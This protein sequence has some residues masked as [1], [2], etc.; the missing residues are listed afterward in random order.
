MISD[1]TKG[2]ESNVR[3]NCTISRYSSLGL[4]EIR[5]AKFEHVRIAPHRLT[6][7]IGQCGLRVVL[8]GSTIYG[9]HHMPSLI[10]IAGELVNSEDVNVTPTALCGSPYCRLETEFLLWVG[11]PVEIS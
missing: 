6:S 8:M 5:I 9:L 4:V 11:T 7:I 1:N 2:L 3:L 10:H